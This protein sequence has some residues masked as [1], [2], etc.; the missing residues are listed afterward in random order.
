VELGVRGKKPLL[1]ELKE[2]V[3]ELLELPLE[4]VE[5]DGREN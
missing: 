2:E 5:P 3:P 1:D 4:D